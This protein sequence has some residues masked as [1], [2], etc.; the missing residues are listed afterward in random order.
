MRSNCERCG[1]S[2][3]EENLNECA[4]CRTETCWK[5]AIHAELP[6]LAKGTWWCDRCLKEVGKEELLKGKRIVSEIAP[7]RYSHGEQVLAIGMLKK[8][9]ADLS[10][11]RKMPRPA[12]LDERAKLLHALEVLGLD[13]GVGTDNFEISPTEMPAG[14]GVLKLSARANYYLTWNLMR[15]VWPTN[16][17]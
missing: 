16:I 10:S 14:P 15:P 13:T 4:R 11:G 5:C 8:F 17:L 9:Y 7:A 3:D 12:D 1:E 2:Y 6:E